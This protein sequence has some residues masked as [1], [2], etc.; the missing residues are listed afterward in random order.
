MGPGAL[1]GF[2]PE[3]FDGA[4]G[5][6]GSLAGKFLLALKVDAILAELLRGEV[7]GGL[8]VVFAELTQAGPV[9][10]FGAGP[11]GQQLQ[12]IGEGF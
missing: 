10:F 2:F 8:V 6:G 4:D 3:Q 5:L 9:G 11:D 1:E 12:V 7:V